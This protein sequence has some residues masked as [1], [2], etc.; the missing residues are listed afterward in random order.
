MC[1]SQEW[2][3]A[4]SLNDTI[5]DSREKSEIIR[6][7]DSEIQKNKIMLFSKTYCPFSRGIKEILFKRL[8]LRNVEVHELDRDRKKTMNVIQDYLQQKTGIRTVP[9]LFIN[10]QF[11]GGFLETSEKN[12]DGRL[13]DILIKA[14]ILFSNQTERR[15]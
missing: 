12:A 7:T 10:G 11:V 4:Y 5:L 13:K 2:S 3:N 14:H 1:S 8:K 6:Q 9:Q 15:I